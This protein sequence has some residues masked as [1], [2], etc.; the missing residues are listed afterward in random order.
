MANSK[1]KRFR[2][3]SLCD[4]R[5]VE[6]KAVLRMISPCVWSV[7]TGLSVLVLEGVVGKG[8]CTVMACTAGGVLEAS[9]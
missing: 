6:T 7:L 9:D 5:R 3:P 2:L 4:K 1:Y 8:K